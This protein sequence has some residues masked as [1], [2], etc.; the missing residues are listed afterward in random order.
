MLTAAGLILIGP[1]GIQL[2]SA[3]AAGM[4]DT[5]GSAAVSSLRMVIAAVVLIAGPSGHFDLLGYAFGLSAAFFFALYTVFAEKVGKDDNGLGGLALS[6]T[7]GAVVS[8]SFGV[9]RVADVTGPQ[10]G[11]LLFS[12]LVGVVLA[13]TVDTIAAR[14]STARVVGTL[15]AID[16]VMGSLVGAVVLDEV[17]SPLAWAGIV[18][19]SGAGALL[20]WASGRRPPAS[21]GRGSSRTGRRWPA[22]GTPCT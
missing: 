19:V 17:I 5:L 13:Y 20:V 6:V 7:V 10:W 21:S 8:L 15:F 18:L 22:T 11:M 4:F 14:V 2:S 9:A 12:A 3:A 16:P 1:L